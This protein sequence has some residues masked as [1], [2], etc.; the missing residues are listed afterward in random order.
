MS[1]NT[2]LT[3]CR[4]LTYM[5]EVIDDAVTEDSTLSYSAYHA[6]RQSEPTF[7]PAISS[8]LPLFQDDSK[9]V[10][11]IRHSMNV[12]H[13]AVNHL[14]PGQVPCICLDQPLYALAKEVQW[15]WP[16]TH[17][18]DKFMIMLGPLHIEMV[19]WKM[20]GQWTDNSGW[21]EGLCQSGVTTSGTADSFIK[22]HH[23][24][25]TKYAHQ[26]TASSLHILMGAAYARY[27][28]E[29]DD[30]EVLSFGQWVEQQCSTSP[31]FLY[32]K[33]TLDLELLVLSFVR[34]V[35]EGDFQLYVA[36]M[37]KLI[38][39]CFALDHTHYARWLTVHI[40]DMETLPTRL[41][42]V[43]TE[44]D[45]GKFVVR[46]TTSKFS[47]LGTDH[48][49]EQNNA[50][51]KEEGGATGLFDNEPALLR[52]MVSGPE[53]ARVVHEYEVNEVHGKKSPSTK[54]HE[55]SRSAQAAFAGDVKK[56]VTKLEEMGNPFLGHKE[57][58]DLHNKDVASP[59]V[60]KSVLT[61]KELGTE[62]YKKFVE[63]R[64]HT[65][66][67]SIHDKLP[68][69]QLVLF[70]T[71]HKGKVNASK[72]QMKVMKNDVSLFSRLYIASQ[73]R[74]SNLGLFFS[75]ENQP[76]PPALSQF[77]ELFQGSK[78]DLLRC[79]P[80]CTQPVE[81]PDCDTLLT[82]GP[83]LVNAIPPRTASTFSDYSKEKFIPY[84]SNAL[85]DVDRADIGM[86]DYRRNSLKAA[87]R[88]K[89]GKGARRKV[90]PNN[91]VPVNWHE[92]LRDDENKTEL[93]G[94]LAEQVSETQ[95]PPG[96]HVYITKGRHVLTSP[97]CLNKT[98]LEPCSHEEADN[99]IFLHAKLA[100]VSGRIKLKM[101]GT[102]T[103][104]VQL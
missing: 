96:K 68:R 77:G 37:K 41:P 17:G 55:Q 101:R 42:Q 8:L 76:F 34:S 94:Y 72:K 89:R 100:V 16:D 11:M 4:W 23:V 102:D 39:W 35:R 50:L 80:T 65:R 78:S 91:K 88:A 62:Q 19:L 97:E 61:V 12:I 20:L 33:D 90:M 26:V 18:E 59:E 28:T 6:S 44:F 104:F 53:V 71:Q 51:V 86:D 84:I 43:Y 95:F 32:W 22:V 24:A 57:L 73:I 81:S 36:S 31:M 10:A 58:F 63:E 49:H 70:G 2:L 79:L 15:S 75:H 64:I 38:P 9:S 52:W 54:H 60:V 5:E 25:R 14:N 40:K 66:E 99:R 30:H 47:A 67:K 56:L 103:Y 1:I 21:T 45:A 46:K 69:N 85:K 83:W 13:A 92:F 98:G 7:M 87:A 93:F 48:A 74:E 29:H 82:D 3:Y 27:T